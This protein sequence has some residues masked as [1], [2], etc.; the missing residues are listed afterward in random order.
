[1]FLS[2]FILKI[3]ITLYLSSSPF[4]YAAVVTYN[5][6]IGWITANPDGEFIR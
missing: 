3:I 1:M 4:S 6:D 5:W 2:Q